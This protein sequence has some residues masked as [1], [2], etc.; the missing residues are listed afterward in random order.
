VDKARTPL[1]QGVLRERRTPA[2]TTTYRHKLCKI[3]V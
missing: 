2:V 1:F 3:P